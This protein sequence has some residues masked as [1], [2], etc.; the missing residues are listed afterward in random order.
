MDQEFQ[1]LLEYVEHRVLGKVVMGL[2]V[3]WKEKMAQKIKEYIKKKMQDWEV[4]VALC[5]E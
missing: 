3:T 4:K 5:M 2:E 1:A